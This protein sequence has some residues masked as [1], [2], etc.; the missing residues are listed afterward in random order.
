MTEYRLEVSTKGHV[1]VIALEGEI[2][3]ANASTLAQRVLD[4]VPDNARGVVL[5]LQGTVYLDSAGIRAFFTL[6]RYLALR[7]QVLAVTV[8]AQSPVRHLLKATRA[9]EVAELCETVDAAVDAV[10]S[11]GL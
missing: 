2:D 7:E 1:P 3:L 5:D 9:N 10:T 4:H 11:A 6:A 8:P